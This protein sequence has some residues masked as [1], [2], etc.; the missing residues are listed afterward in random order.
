MP[1]L[2]IK[3]YNI[4]KTPNL[5]KMYICPVYKTVA[6]QVKGGVG[7]YVF[8]AQ[9]RTKEPADKWTCAGVGLILDVEGFDK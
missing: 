7:G 9:L 5:T 6:R 8:P 2:I 4:N 1:V 3:S